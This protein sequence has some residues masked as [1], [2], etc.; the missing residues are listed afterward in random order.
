MVEEIS[1][2]GLR[3]V[4]YARWVVGEA[5]LISVYIVLFLCCFLHLDHV[6]CIYF[7]DVSCAGFRMWY[8][9]EFVYV[10]CRV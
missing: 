6:L 4:G 10:M 7:E 1:A 3:A 8:V 2:Y 9:P 5:R